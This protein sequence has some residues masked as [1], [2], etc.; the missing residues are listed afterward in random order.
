M[1]PISKRTRLIGFALVATTFFISLSVLTYMHFDE[2]RLFSEAVSLDTGKNLHS[3]GACQHALS[4]VFAS[5]RVIRIGNSVNVEALFTV[6]KQDTCT[7]SARLSAAAFDVE[8]SGNQ[9]HEVE[10]G[11]H[12]FVW[13]VAPKSIGTHVINIQSGLRTRTI[14]ISVR[15]VFWLTQLQLAI[16]SI[17]CAILGPLLTA[18]WWLKQL[19]FVRS[20]D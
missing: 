14:G 6:P 7:I 18:P 10:S 5:D 9:T 4:T 11:L 17:F 3:S 8:P 16:I 1:N 15:N 12:T 2:Q 19:G 20:D 13:N